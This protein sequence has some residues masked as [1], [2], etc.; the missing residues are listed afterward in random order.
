MKLNHQ[1]FLMRQFQEIALVL[2]KVMG[3]GEQEK[4]QEGHELID[5][6]LQSWFGGDREADLFLEW[7]EGEL[8]AFLEREMTHESGQNALA[9]LLA[10][11]GHLK[12]KEGFMQEGQ[13][14]LNK[15]LY[16]L[17]FIHAHSSTYD[18]ERVG[19]I[20]SLEKAISLYR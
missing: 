14:Y 2:A 13:K 9:Q 15:S 19:Q 7:E 18:F 17:Q 8:L 3:F 16:I 1:D 20:A 11:K 12:I 6:R 10:A 5:E 4:Y